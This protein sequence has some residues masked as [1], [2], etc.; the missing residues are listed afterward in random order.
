[1]LVR[2]AGVG[3]IAALAAAG[4]HAAAQPAADE[5]PYEATVRV[6]DTVVNT[7]KPL[8][9]GDNIE[10][11]N[12]G[13][14]IWQ[15]ERGDFDASIAQMIREAGVTHLRYP[16]GTLSDFFEWRKAVGDARQPIPNPFAE[17]KGRPDMPVFGPEEFMRLCRALDIPGTITLNA[18]TGT[19]EDAA[20][21]VE[22]FREHDFPVTDYTV[23]NEIYMVKGLE[24]PIP[25]LPIGKGPDEYADLYLAFHEAIEAVAP[26]TKLGAIGLH[27]TTEI[28][29]NQHPTWI[30]TLLRRCGDKMDF[31]DIHTGYAPVIRTGIT[32]GARRLDDEDFAEAFMAASIWVGD[33]VR[34]TE[35]DLK[36]YAPEGGG[37]I[38]I[39]ITEYGPL[40]YPFAS[41]DAGDDLQWNR[42][43]TGALYL[44]CLFN[45]LAAEPKV[46]SANH[47][48]LCQDVFGALVGFR[49][50]SRAT[51]RNAVFHVFREYSALS[52]RDVLATETTGP[53]YS[54]QIAGFIPPLADVP[55]VDAGAYRSDDGEL[56]VCLINRN[57]HRPAKVTLEL[58]RRMRPRR[59]T[60][61]TAGSFRSENTPEAP[62]AVMPKPLPMLKSAEDRIEVE[63]PRHSFVV[64]ELG[65][66]EV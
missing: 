46:T 66:S 22:Y 45:Q 36:D 7:V 3:L 54:T 6:T 50:P 56:T 30:P 10:W 44:A 5:T 33:N 34:L 14:G 26:G 11:T 58:G 62:D 47:L 51:W 18:G 52:G 28:S 39:H 38:E 63:V 32:P 60:V 2:A 9:F 4:T 31:L 41:G 59:A 17:P 29:L 48:P 49:Y 42:S 40:V 61:L 21:W 25:D 19:A 55:Y 1:M 64:V 16:G 8:L 57:V 15:P 24:E 65:G 27:S 20:A 43:L 37:N 35:Q 13:M 23:G 53:T 12:N